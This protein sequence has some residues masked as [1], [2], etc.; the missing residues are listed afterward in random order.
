MKSV[1]S[2]AGEAKKNKKSRIK[3]R[4]LISDYASKSGLVQ[5]VSI[6]QMT[7]VVPLPK[8]TVEEKNNR[9]SEP[10]SDEEDEKGKAR[11]SSR[12]L[13]RSNL[14]QSEKN[15]KTNGKKRKTISPNRRNVVKIYFF[16]REKTINLNFP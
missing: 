7:F 6:I 8:P 4:R 10:N 2:T 3:T 5:P 9:H 14:F 13:R 15:G 16:S 12:S 1:C 11:Q